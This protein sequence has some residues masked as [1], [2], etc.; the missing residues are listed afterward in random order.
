MT[1]TQ[2]EF[3]ELSAG[4]ALGALDDAEMRAFRRAC[5]EHPEWKEIADLDAETA[6]GL[7]ESI[8]EVAP[9]AAIRESILTRIEALPQSAAEDEQ[10]DPAPGAVPAP[11]R[12][13][14]RARRRWFALAASL[15]LAAGIGTGAVV[16]IQHLQQPPAVV[17]L[18]RI[19]DA[20]DAQQA[21]ARVAGGSDATLHWSVS[22][23]KAVLVTNGMP[24]LPAG[25]T[26]ELWY[27]RG[28][29]AI[30]AGT[31]DAGAASAL[32]KPGMRPGD[33]IAVTVERAGGSET[34]LPTSQ[35]ILAIPTA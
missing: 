22:E 4:A 8:D 11:M 32:L 6:A 14:H 25:R 34:G 33:T 18:N 20:P 16:A 15:V 12:H 21:T 17:A 30:P 27:V 19:V 31:F 35:P 2:D 7:A 13:P 29:T 5:A 28:E 24:A 3:A 9:P 26:F 10:P 23:G 1:M